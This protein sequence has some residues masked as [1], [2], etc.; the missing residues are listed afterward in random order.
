VFSI[1]VSTFV[2]PFRLFLAAI[3]VVTVV[4]VTTAILYWLQWHSSSGLFGR[5]RLF[6]PIVGPP[7]LLAS[8]AFSSAPFYYS[9]SHVYCCR[10]Y[11]F[12]PCVLCFFLGSFCDSK[13]PVYCRRLYHFSPPYAFSFFLGS[14]CGS[15]SPV[16]CRHPYHCHYYWRSFPEG[17]Q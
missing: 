17:A 2:S 12:F 5:L 16:D 15:R 11:H 9:R 3:V 7:F 8:F 6:L 1:L 14:F 4:V 10:L 13:G